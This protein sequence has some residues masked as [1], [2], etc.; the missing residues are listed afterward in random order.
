MECIRSLVYSERYGIH[1]IVSNAET[2][3]RVKFQ[4][5]YKQVE[6]VLEVGPDASVETI[7]K[8]AV[9]AIEKY[10]EEFQK[11]NKRRL[12]LHQWYLK[13]RVEEKGTFLS[14][15]GVVTGHEYLVDSMNVCTS[16]V[17]K[18]EI[19]EAAGEAVIYTRN[20]VYYCPLI[21]CDF[22]EQ[23]KAPNFV[24][25][26][27]EIK[28]EYKGKGYQPSIDPGNV[29]LVLSDHNE[30]YYNSLISWSKEGELQEI[31][32]GPN[33]GMFQD[34]FLINTLDYSIEIRYFPH[35]QNIELY[36]EE[37][38]GNRFFVENIGGCTLCVKAGCGVIRLEP[39]ERKE[40]IKE[41]TEIP[42]PRL[43]RS[44]LYPAFL[45]D[46]D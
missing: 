7:E 21:S 16:E 38:A 15:Y 20:S 9:D 22:D 12:M 29:L 44:E 14:A 27:E 45:D 13:E 28:S 34:S 33:I 41:N 19:D 23:D 30:Y 36:M 3:V 43:D 6:K 24:P 4:H 5:D 17:K 31:V 2:V 11:K 46:E 25:K 10:T 42:L 8:I 39:G 1:G 18:V 32:A 40:V 26:Y 35:Y 37:L